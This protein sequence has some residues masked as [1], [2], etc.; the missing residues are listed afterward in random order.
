[1][2]ER[3]ILGYQSK[4]GQASDP[5]HAVAVNLG[6]ACP[7]SVPTPPDVAV[8]IDDLAAAPTRLLDHLAL[9]HVCHPQLSHQCP[10]LGRPHSEQ[11]GTCSA[12]LTRKRRTATLTVSPL[13][14]ARC[15]AASHNSSSTRIMRPGLFG[16]GWLTTSGH[17]RQAAPELHGASLRGVGRGM[18]VVPTLL[19][20]GFVCR[21]SHGGRPGAARVARPGEVIDGRD[22]DLG[23]LL[24][25]HGASSIVAQR[26]ADAE[27]AD[28]GRRAADLMGASVAGRRVTRL[29]RALPTVEA[30]TGDL[31][32]FHVSKL[33]GVHTP[34]QHTKVAT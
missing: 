23:V 28:W 5:H 16:L 21:Q 4:P 29:I 2:S 12:Y 19:A 24:V 27:R 6:G 33:A 31:A 3:P 10:G 15:L 7:A 14:D 30:V 13:R 25:H 17:L 18:A 11:T 1:M 8:T 34:C 26:G 20:D 22:H 32:R 9:N